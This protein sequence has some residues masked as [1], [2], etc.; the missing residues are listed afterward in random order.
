MGFF[1]VVQV[2]KRHSGLREK[3]LAIR[4][5]PEPHAEEQVE[6]RSRLESPP[7]P[8]AGLRR[9]QALSHNAVMVGRDQFRSSCER[10][11]VVDIRTFRATSSAPLG[12]RGVA[13]VLGV[14]VTVSACIRLDTS[15]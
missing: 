15:S 2:S 7:S 3:T 8:T 4:P 9:L 12:A 1:V 14:E 13:N 6:L 5:L 10:G 11:S